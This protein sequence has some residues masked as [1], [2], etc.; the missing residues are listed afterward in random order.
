M[1][2]V[3]FFDLPVETPKQRKDYRL[4]RKFLLKDGFLPL[5]QSVYVKLVVN[6]G[7]ASS[8]VARVRKHRPP[9]GI[10]SDPQGYGNAVFNHGIHYGKASGL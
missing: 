1:R 3:L 9:A 6:D 4:F 10:G 7:V 2:L 5:Q 8:A